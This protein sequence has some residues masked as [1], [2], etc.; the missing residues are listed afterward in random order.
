MHTPVNWKLEEGGKAQR[1]GSEVEE[2]VFC[3]TNS[4]ATPPSSHANLCANLCA[5]EATLMTSPSTK[6]L[7]K[8]LST[9][10][11]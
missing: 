1:E 4:L 8:S 5:P 9:F 6:G 7:G 10:R 3:A 11:P 2:C